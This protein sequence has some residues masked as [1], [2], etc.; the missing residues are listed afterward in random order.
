MRLATKLLRP[1]YKYI[2]QVRVEPSTCNNDI[3]KTKRKAFADTLLMHMARGDYIVY[4][5]ETNY[6]LYSRRTQGR[7]KVGQR[8]VAV[9][10]LS[11]GANLQFKCAA[12]TTDGLILHRMQRGSI[13]MEENAEFAEAIYHAVKSLPSFQAE[14]CGKVVVI[15]PAHSQTETRMPGHDDSVLLRLG[16]HLPMCN[17][18]E[19]C[20]SVLK[21]K[22]KNFLASRR[23]EMLTAG[24]HA[25]LTEARMDLLERAAVESLSCLTA[26]LTTK[27]S[28][29]YDL[30][31]NTSTRE[32]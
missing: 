27:M 8:V 10:Q 18:I 16:P 6:N 22:I 17:P 23:S 20:F 11:K 2:K 1:S 9:L 3:N 14:F 30:L 5:D 24:A 12:S 29:H 26:V 15:A 32:S 28:L 21:A 19:G 13:R 7:A 25:T 31:K 4:Y